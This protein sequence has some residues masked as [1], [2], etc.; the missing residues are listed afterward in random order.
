M[1]YVAVAMMI[2]V[3]CASLGGLFEETETSQILLILADACTVPGVL[4]VGI[5]LIGWVGSKGTFDIFGYSMKGLFSLWSKESYYHR[6]SFYD[7]R[8][9]KDKERKP[10]NRAMLFVG[11]VMLILAVLFSVLFTVV[12]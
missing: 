11:I 9:E 10:F 3:V 5:T 4:L 8:Q 2:F 6:E 1:V 7:Y 12:A